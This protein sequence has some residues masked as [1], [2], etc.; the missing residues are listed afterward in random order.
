MQQKGFPPGQQLPRSTG[1]GWKACRGLKLGDVQ[2]NKCKYN[3]IITHVT[4][5]PTKHHLY[6]YKKNT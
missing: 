1:W 3:H 6:L 5:K 4:F 2:P